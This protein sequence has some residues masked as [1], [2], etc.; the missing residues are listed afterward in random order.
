MAFSW[1]EQIV[2]A[3]FLYLRPNFSSTGFLMKRTLGTKINNK[4]GQFKRSA[5]TYPYSSSTSELSNRR[6]A[7]HPV[8][9]HIHVF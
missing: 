4:R 3:S 8:G 5:T 2:D 9:V 7:L 1:L 6:A